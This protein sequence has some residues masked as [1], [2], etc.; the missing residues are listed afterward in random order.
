VERTHGALMALQRMDAVARNHPM[1]RSGR[2]RPCAKT[3]CLTF[4]PLR[5]STP[6][7]GLE[8]AFALKYWPFY[9]RNRIVP[10]G[11]DVDTW[12]ALMSCRDIACREWN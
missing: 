9:F 4:E 11:S 5:T 8:C 2:G 6:S 1:S 7:R 12:L 3:G 10:K